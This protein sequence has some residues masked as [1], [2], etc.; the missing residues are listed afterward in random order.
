V[1]IIAKMR[2]D[3]AWRVLGIC[4]RL[5]VEILLLSDHT[6]KSCSGAFAPLVTCVA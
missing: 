2:K 5:L 6:S 1:C 4:Q 3:V